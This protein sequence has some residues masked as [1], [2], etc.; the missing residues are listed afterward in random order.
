VENVEFDSNNRYKSWEHCYNFF[1]QD[2][3]LLRNNKFDEASLNLAFYL[4]SWGMYRGSSG[5]LWKDYK[6]HK[7]YLGI[8]LEDRYASL[9]NMR[10]SQMNSAKT[11]HIQNL[12]DLSKRIKRRI[13]EIPYWKRNDKAYKISA[14]DTLVTKILMGTLGCTPAFDNF[15]KEGC[16]E[17]NKYIENKITPYSNFNEKSYLGLVNF[18]I[19]H[20]EQFEKA[21]KVIEDKLNMKYPDMKLLDMYLWQV[22]FQNS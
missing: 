4:A 8:I 2:F 15:F 10:L 14:T 5:L 22:G 7:K 9:R 18:F 21:S 12:F 11:S 17:L 20:R 3:E 6:I 1:D 16:A 13:N 19:D